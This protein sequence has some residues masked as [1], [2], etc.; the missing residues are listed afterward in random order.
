MTAQMEGPGG[1]GYFSQPPPAPASYAQRG[2]GPFFGANTRLELHGA[3]LYDL[4][5]SLNNPTENPY[6][7]SSPEGATL[8][9]SLSSPPASG[10]SGGRTRDGRP[11][12]GNITEV[13]KLPEPEPPSAE[14]LHDALSRLP[15]S[16]GGGS[17][18]YALADAAAFAP[19]PDGAIPARPLEPRH[20][21]CYAR[22]A[23]MVPSRN[24][25]HVL[26]CQTCGSGS[27]SGSGAGGGPPWRRV[28]AWC[29]L[30]VC[31]D[32]AGLLARHGGDLGRT[33]EAVGV[34]KRLE[35][36]RARH[37]DVGAASN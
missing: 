20:Y 26:A 5:E 1:G 16:N 27:G 6:R 25:N 2:P 36:G 32:C 11:P 37:G 17:G 21:T 9:S 19:G 10:G 24:R 4:V 30:R 34:R 23:T 28:C 31:E 8:S 13:S 18:G 22:H 14:A 33:L 3:D 12:L 29:S 15:L 35:K 7:T